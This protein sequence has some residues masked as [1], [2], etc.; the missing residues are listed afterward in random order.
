MN[1]RLYRSVDDRV[2]AGVCGGLAVRLGMDPSLVR[3]A[4]ALVALVTGVFPLLVLYVIMAAV[5]PEE[6]TG[7]AGVGRSPTPAGPGAVPGWAPPAGAPEWPPADAAA[8][9]AWAASPGTGAE[10]AGGPGEATTIAPPAEP[11]TH[12]G[13]PAAPPPWSQ[14]PGWEP[15]ERRE[16]RADPLLAIVGGLILVGLG[17]YFLVRD[18]VTVDWSVV[19]PAALVALGAVVMIA[20]FRPRR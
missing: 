8:P 13:P 6:P 4:Y 2:I 14:P 11:P 1:D 7:F 16:R 17:V 9:A 18:Q 10:A 19:W 15:Q 12:V 20:A 5:V 3:I